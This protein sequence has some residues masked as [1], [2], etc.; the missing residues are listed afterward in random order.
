MTTLVRHQHPPR[1]A[2]GVD[3]RTVT[4]DPPL[5]LE[6]LALRH[7]ATVERFERTNREFFAQHV[8]DRGDDYFEN[9]ALRLADLV[10]DNDAG[11]SLCFVLT[12]PAG[13]V[14][15]RVNVYGIERPADTEL[16]FRVAERAQ[17]T[18]VATGGVEAALRVAAAQGVQL[19]T[20]R[21]ATTNLG[22][23]RVLTKCG[24]V[25]TGRAEAPPGSHRTFLGYRRL[26]IPAGGH[27]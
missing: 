2:E 13:E 17:N 15:G 21:A 14:H 18:G 3:P 22:S 8:S 12:D 9:F 20:A 27:A 10:E 4:S 6:L 7:A 1:H 16:G 5:Q 24:F 26:L 25:A 11:R 19:V 23:Q